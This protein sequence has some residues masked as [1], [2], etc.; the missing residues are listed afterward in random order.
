M[1]RDYLRAAPERAK[2]YADKKCQLAKA[3]PEDMA[4]YMNG[5]NTIIKEIEQETYNWSKQFG[6]NDQFR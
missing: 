1:F 5:K 6:T 2:D 3:H 4:S